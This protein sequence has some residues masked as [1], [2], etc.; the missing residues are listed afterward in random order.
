M[1]ELYFKLYACCAFIHPGLDGLL[2]IMQADGVQAAG[3][4]GV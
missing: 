2:D 3:D 4:R 1:M